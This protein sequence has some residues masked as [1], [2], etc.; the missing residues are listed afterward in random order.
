MKKWTDKLTAFDWQLLQMVGAVTGA[1][2]EPLRWDAGFSFEADYGAH[3]PEWICGLI[4][5]IE[6]RAGARLVEVQDDAER[7]RL[8]VRVRFAEA[9]EEEGF[10]PAAWDGSK[11]NIG[12]R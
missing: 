12:S 8:F 7:H 5:A 3:T 10:C 6:G 4:D 9:C 2:C 1:A 11:D